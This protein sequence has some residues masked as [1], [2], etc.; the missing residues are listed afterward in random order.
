MTTGMTNT[1]TQT[2]R[3]YRA[4]RGWGDVNWQQE[5]RDKLDDLSRAQQDTALAVARLMPRDQTESLVAT[6]VSL[7]TFAGYRTEVETRFKQIESQPAN[8]RANL[9]LIIAAI[10]V[11]VTLLC[12]STEVVIA[13]AGLLHIAGL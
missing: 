4:G 12:G 7:D 1:T 2:P 13:L 3:H 5:M 9:S 10:A 8:T 11:F 6:R